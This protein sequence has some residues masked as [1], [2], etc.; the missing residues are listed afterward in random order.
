MPLSTTDLEDPLHIDVAPFVLQDLAP[1]PKVHF[2]FATV[3]LAQA[4]VVRH[5][6]LRGILLREDLATAY[7]HRND[8]R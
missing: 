3:L 2:V 7:A 8:R 1:M 5:G 6:K 4:L